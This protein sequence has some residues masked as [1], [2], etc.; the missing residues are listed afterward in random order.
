MI[1]SRIVAPDHSTTGVTGGARHAGLLA[2]DS[3][4]GGN[5]PPLRIGSP[6]SRTKQHAR[7]FQ[8]SGCE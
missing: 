7:L 6:D 8:G 3:S 5:G 2:Q 4:R 1:G